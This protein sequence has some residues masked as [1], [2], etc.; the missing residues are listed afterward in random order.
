MLRSSM[1]I[2]CET[3]RGYRIAAMK[4]CLKQEST[5]K[6][7]GLLISNPVELQRTFT[8]LWINE[9]RSFLANHDLN[10]RVFSGKKYYSGTP[11][12]TLAQL[13]RNEPQRAWVITES[14]SII[15]SWFESNRVNS[16]IV[17]SPHGETSI[18]SV[19]LNYRAVGRHAAGQFLRA[20]HRAIAIMV[21]DPA[22]GGDNECRAGFEEAV[23][24]HSVETIDFIVARH[25]FTPDS[26]FRSIQLLV[27]R[28]IT[29]TALL[30]GNSPY[31]LAAHTALCSLGL[32]IPKD[33]TL[34]SR[35][36]DPYLKFVHP[37]PARYSCPPALMAKRIGRILLKL[38]EVSTT[39]QVPEKLMPFFLEG[40]TLA[41]RSG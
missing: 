24:A 1:L 38:H 11:G 39:K 10:L 15:Q 6:G 8:N 14:T 28:K 2:Q 21:G 36:D 13:I 37:E 32:K 16:V 40:A 27:R 5:T 19:D 3:G 18:P 41:K 25:T 20:G 17:G 9:L 23:K 7:V 26:I 4:E 29:P 12:K 30:V 31:Y 33:I 22:R 35:D 34:I